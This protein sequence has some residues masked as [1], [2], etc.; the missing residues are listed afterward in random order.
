[1]PLPDAQALAAT[2]NTPS[3]EEPWT[4]VEDY[5][6]VLEY[7]A[8]HPDKGSSAVST[9][10]DLPRSRI[11]PWMNGS[12]PDVVRGIQTAEDHGWLQDHSTPETRRAL[13][14]LAAWV[15]SGGNLRVEEDARVYFAL[16][17][18]LEAEFERIAD[19]AGVAYRTIRDDEE[20]HAT[21][22]RIKEHGSVLA[23]V[24]WAMGVP[25]GAK[26]RQEPKALPSF[27]SHL[28]D[29]LLEA[30]ARVYL[31][32]RGAEHE[33][34]ATLTIREERPDSYLDELVDVLREASGERVTRTGQTVTVSA[35]AARALLG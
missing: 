22:V 10:L 20:G 12:R 11:R 4:A 14:E 2:Y 28:D 24:L 9:A 26:S 23:R 18:G 27:V 1:M 6:R 21:E 15:L 30:F 7:T 13:V 32:N 5:Q 34:K 29:E 19:D 33:N 3:Y 35:D 16:D 8:D 17:D 25:S 31:L